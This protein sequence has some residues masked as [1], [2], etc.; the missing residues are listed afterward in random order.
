MPSAQL[1]LVPSTNLEETGSQI[2][3]PCPPMVHIRGGSENPELPP[4]GMSD[5]AIN[6]DKNF[7]GIMETVFRKHLNMS[8]VQQFFLHPVD[9][10]KAGFDVDGS[11]VLINKIEA[12][13]KELPGA[14]VLIKD[15]TVTPDAKQSKEWKIPKLPSPNDLLR[16]TLG[17]HLIA[18]GTAK[19]EGIQSFYKALVEVQRIAQGDGYGAPCLEIPA[20]S[21]YKVTVDDGS[22]KERILLSQKTD[23]TT[24]ISVQAVKDKIV[25]NAITEF[26]RLALQKKVKPFTGWKDTINDADTK[27]V[28]MANE[29]WTEKSADG[30][31]WRDRFVEQGILTSQEAKAVNNKLTDAAGEFLLDKRGQEGGYMI[32]FGNFAGDILQDIYAKMDGG[33]GLISSRSYGKLDNGREVIMYDSGAGTDPRHAEL[34]LQGKRSEVFHNP[35]GQII[36][37]ARAIDYMSARMPEACA[38]RKLLEL[39]TSNVRGAIAD[40]I[41]DGKHMPDTVAA[42]GTR[43]TADMV[44]FV[45]AVDKALSARM[46]SQQKIVDV[47]M[48][49]TSAEVGLKVARL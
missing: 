24:T 8:A 46:Q 9:R 43:G 11:E 33:L 40:A 2:K 37:V 28:T 25:C 23:S 41:K 18:R 32:L 35:T 30:Q 44:T 26:F 31:C 4:V 49:Q 12:A 19:I 14:A 48:K 47:L 5:I 39:F 15:P 7:S 10:A 1:Q 16:R 34:W 36:A 22:G 3:I 29:I 42:N 20:N 13:V 21:V 6:G 38:H 17:L 45:T 27:F